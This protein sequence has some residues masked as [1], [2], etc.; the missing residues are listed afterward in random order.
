MRPKGLHLPH[1]LEPGLLALQAPANR[2]LRRRLRLVALACGVAVGACVGLTYRPAIATAASST[3]PS[4]PAS[5]SLQ[6]PL[7]PKTDIG[8]TISISPLL[9]DFVAKVVLRW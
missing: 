8:Q 6:R 7:G 4:L 1:E 3:P 9:A 2:Y 5:R